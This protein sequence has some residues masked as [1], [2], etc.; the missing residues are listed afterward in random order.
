MDVQARHAPLR[1]RRRR[2][3]LQLQPTTTHFPLSLIYDM[4]AHAGA[5]LA[6]LASTLPDSLAAAAARCA[7]STCG[8]VEGEREGEGEGGSGSEETAYDEVVLCHKN[9]AVWRGDGTRY[10]PGEYESEVY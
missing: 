8:S 6:R 5:V 10:R 3:G 7:E 4:S 2:P 9:W 1:R